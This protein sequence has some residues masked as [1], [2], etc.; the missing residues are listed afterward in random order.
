MYPYPGTF[1]VQIDAT[2]VQSQQ[3]KPNMCVISPH[4]AITYPPLSHEHFTMVLTTAKGCYFRSFLHIF[5]CAAILFP[6]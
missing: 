2:L 4:E 1:W 3:T 5:A 6:S